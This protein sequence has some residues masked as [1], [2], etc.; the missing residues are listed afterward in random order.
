M[1]L[2]HTPQH[3]KGGPVTA[4]VPRTRMYARR[5]NNRSKLLTKFSFP[6]V[7]QQQNAHWEPLMSL[8]VQMAAGQ[9]C[10]FRERACTSRAQGSE[11]GREERLQAAA[12]CSSRQQP[13]A[14]DD[15]SATAG[16]TVLV[17][18]QQVRQCWL[19]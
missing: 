15:S 18:P 19:V 3:S 11:A 1:Q 2:Q 5:R 16:T 14:S 12:L 10:C 9:V 8:A 7:K 6:Q 13:L 4:A 17:A